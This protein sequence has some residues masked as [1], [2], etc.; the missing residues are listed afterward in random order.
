M[1]GRTGPA[2]PNWKGGGSPERQ[3]LY[4]SGE[5]RRL[6]RQLRVRAG[7]ACEE[8]GATEHLH[9]HHVKSWAS[10]PELRLELDNLLLLCAVCHRAKHRREVRY[11]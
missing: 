11:Q 4:S 7:G 1:A 9:M 10:H 6:R 5:W 3:R 2:N 8:C